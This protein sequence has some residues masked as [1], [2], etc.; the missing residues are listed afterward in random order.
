MTKKLILLFAYNYVTIISFAQ[1]KIAITIDDVPN[2]KNFEKDNFNSR[3][4]YKLDSIKIPV[5]IFI[6]EGLLSK[7]VHETKNLDLLNNWIA[8]DYTTIGNHTFN[9]SRF[10]DTGIDSFLT[11]V[12]KG[13]IYTRKIAEQYGKSLYHFR[14]P[15][16]DLGKDSLQRKEIT[17]RLSEKGYMISPFTIESSD[18]MFNYLYEYYLSNGNKL[19]ADSIGSLYVHKTLEYFFFFDSLSKNIYNRHINQIYL[20]HDNSIN[21]DYL[22]IV[23]KELQQKKYSFI[24]LDEAMLDEVYR[25]ENTYYKKWG[26]SWIYRWMDDPNNVKQVMQKEPDIMSIYNT[27]KK[28]NQ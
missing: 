15:Y 18:W 25:S 27:Y 7:T 9:H 19:K 4:L 24:S 3:L 17:R 14:F 1:T 20:C 26:I 21:A 16:N 28:L 6:N 5:A 12:D 10:S 8:R 13:E 11:D 23:I 2:T 22:N